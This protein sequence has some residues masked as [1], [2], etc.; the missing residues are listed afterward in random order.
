MTVLCQVTVDSGCTVLRRP[1]TKSLILFIFFFF[2]LSPC[3][4][5]TKTAVCIQIFYV[6][7]DCPASKMFLF[8][9]QRCMWVMAGRVKPYPYTRVRFGL[10]SLCMFQVHVQL[11]N[12]NHVKPLPCPQHASHKSKTG[13][14]SFMLVVSGIWCGNAGHFIHCLVFTVHTSGN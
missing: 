6:Q 9:G 11:K 7:N 12:Y 10:T 14:G 8:L 3:Q 1:S 13:C 5:S 2:L 4:S